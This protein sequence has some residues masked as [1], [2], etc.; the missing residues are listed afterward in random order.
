MANPYATVLALPGARGFVV[1]GV[2]GRLPIS[3]LGLGTVVLVERRYG[4]YGLAGAVSATLVVSVAAAGPPVSRLLDR[5]GQARVL[6][7]AL[8]VHVAGLVALL[9]AAQAAAP[10]WVLFPAAAVAGAASPPLSACVRARWSA[11]L[12]GRPELKT[13]FAFESVADEVVFIVGAVLV[14]T[15]AVALSPL[16]GLACALVFVTA[17]TLAFAAQRSTE[18]PP[19][20][21]ARGAGTTAIARPGLRVLVAAFLAVGAIFGALEVAMVAFAEEE[22]AEGAA[23]ALLALVAGSSLAS[24]LAY[25]A[26]TWA[27]APGRRLA[28]GVAVMAA[29]IVPVALAATVPQMA[30]AAVLTGLAISP[31]LIASYEVVEALVPATALTEGFAWITTALAVGVADGAGFAVSVQAGLVSAAAVVLGARWRRETAPAAGRP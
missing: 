25:G 24:G 21:A 23:G 7:P 17:G 2:V 18:P 16:A 8:G 6:V 27:S 30:G 29:G 31:T 1:A 4:S 5:L 28:V 20:G 10:R 15:L 22:G 12:R 13:A 11:L 9:V 26:R 14:T 3:M 19:T